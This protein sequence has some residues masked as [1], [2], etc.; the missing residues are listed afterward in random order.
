MLFYKECS[1]LL[2]PSDFYCIKSGGHHVVTKGQIGP[3]AGG[4]HTH[5]LSLRNA[6]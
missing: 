5:L 4:C 3:G 2:I 1:C 6:S